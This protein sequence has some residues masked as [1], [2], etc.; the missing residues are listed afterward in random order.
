MNNTYKN[1]LVVMVAAILTAVMCPAVV[2]AIGNV[3]YIE[4]SPQK[5]GFSLVQK[6]NV[7]TLYVDSQDYAG[8]IRAVK[9]L[10]ADIERVADKIPKLVH[11]QTDLRENI[12]IIGTIGKS[13][14]ID[15]LI[16]ANKIDVEQIVGK[17]ESCFIKGVSETLAG[18]CKGLVK[19]A[20]RHGIG[21]RMSRL[22]I[23]KP[24]LSSR[25]DIRKA[26]RRSNTG[27]FS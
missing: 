14:L 1:E 25:D 22:N 7:A 6:E 2:W 12:V 21:G 23:K 15:K 27:A 9:N 4:T 10:Q 11:E 20:F 8:V 26:N 18:V 17:W 5:G 19:S 3:R 13:P 24:C 16:K